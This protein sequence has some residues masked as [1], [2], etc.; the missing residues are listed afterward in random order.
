MEE[1]PCRDKI[2]FATKEAAEGAA[3]LAKHRYGKRSL[4]A[5]QCRHCGDWHLARDHNDETAE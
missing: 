3:A 5:Y 4:K 2:P 1:N